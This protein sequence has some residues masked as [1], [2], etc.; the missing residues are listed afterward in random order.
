[1]PYCAI[2]LGKIPRWPA[3]VVITTRNIAVARAERIPDPSLVPQ[4]I[5]LES[6][7]PPN[8]SGALTCAA[9]VDLRPSRRYPQLRIGTTCRIANIYPDDS[10]RFSV[11]ARAFAD[12]NQLGGE[13]VAASYEEARS[14]AL[15][16]LDYSGEWLGKRWFEEAPSPDGIVLP[17]QKPQITGQSTPT[18]LWDLPTLRIAREERNEAS[19]RQITAMKDVG[20]SD[21]S[22]ILSHVASQ[23]GARDSEIAASGDSDVAA[24]RPLARSQTTLTKQ[25]W[26]S[27]WTRLSRELRGLCRISR[28]DLSCVTTEETI[29]LRR[30]EPQRE[31]LARISGD[32]ISVSCRGELIT[33]QVSKS[34]KRSLVFDGPERIASLPAFATWMLRFFILDDA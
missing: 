18:L 10:R 6:P 4:R 34:L 27:L 11:E 23:I 17:Y 13:G 19:R 3:D 25:E 21:L 26:A 12:E 24:E 32:S 9:Y 31:A 15:S 30:S 2:Q 8:P 29:L 7:P 28:R 5:F 14:L 16:W 33:F 20:D 1:M 22:Q